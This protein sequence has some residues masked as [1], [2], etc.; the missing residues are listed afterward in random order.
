MRNN[1]VQFKKQREIGEI[2]ADTF[3]FIRLEFRG[4]FTAL[5]RNAGIPFLFLLAGTGYYTAMSANINIFTM[6]GLG[7]LGG[8]LLI[9]FAFLLI[10][11]LL[12]YG[13]MFG[14]VLNYIKSYINHSGAA[15]QEEVRSGVRDNLG[16][17]VLATITLGFMLFV[18]IML[19]VIPGIY[20]YAT[21]STVYAILVFENKGSIDSISDS[22]NLI[23]GE[24][25][26]TFATLIVVNII[27]WLISLVFQLPT[28]VYAVIKAMTQSEK[29]SG[30]DMSGMFDWIYVTLNVVG[31]GV[32]YIMNT[33]V[34]IATAFIYFNLNERKNQTGTLEQ[35]ESIGDT[36]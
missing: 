28:F 3:A 18:G 22:F 17:L 27:V 5:M 31:S 6:G 2:L 11:T 35:I 21:L 23:K 30:G 29:L 8:D 19:C 10:T 20:L 14:S 7:A 25:W 34:V 26:T 9:A 24:W 33:I 1:F 12:F 32:S 4:L 36:P 16:G 13:F 15:D